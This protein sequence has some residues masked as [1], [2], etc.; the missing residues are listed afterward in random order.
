MGEV[1][2]QKAR[3]IVVL[4]HSS[5]HF[6]VSRKSQPGQPGQSK[7]DRQAFNDSRLEVLCALIGRVKAHCCETALPTSLV[8][9]IEP[10]LCRR[11]PSRC[12]PLPRSSEAVSG[13]ACRCTSTPC[14]SSPSC[15]VRPRNLSPTPVSEASREA[16]T[17]SDPLSRVCSSTRA[18]RSA[19]RYS[20]S[21]ACAS[22]RARRRAPRR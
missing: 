3:L 18:R 13:S 4:S 7:A 2:H 21:R 11:R 20:G 16:R 5:R 17:G 15:A 10:R 9:H 8:A 19:R 12:P 1:G 22:P 6:T 14:A